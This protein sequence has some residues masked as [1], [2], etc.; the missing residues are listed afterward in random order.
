[1]LLPP[2][3]TC[4]HRLV[5]EPCVHTHKCCFAVKKQG[6]KGNNEDGA[7]SEEENVTGNKRLRA[8]FEKNHRSQTVRSHFDSRLFSKTHTHERVLSRH[9]HT[10]PLSTGEGHGSEEWTRRGEDPI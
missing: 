8:T 1:M 2:V 3:K 4:V 6:H 7:E 5:N 10:H 9:T